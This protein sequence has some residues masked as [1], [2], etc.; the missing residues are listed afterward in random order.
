LLE[1]TV[2]IINQAGV[3]ISQEQRTNEDG[4][5]DINILVRAV[6]NSLSQNVAAGRGTLGKTLGL[7]YGLKRRAA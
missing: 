7:T 3:A 4:S 5:T 2:N 6:E 1:H